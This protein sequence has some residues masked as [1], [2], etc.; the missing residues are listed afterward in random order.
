M[1]R[2]GWLVL[3][4]GSRYPVSRFF[5]WS[6][7]SCSA[8]C[9]FPFVCF[10]ALPLC[11]FVCLPSWRGG[12]HLAQWGDQICCVIGW[13]RLFLRRDISWFIN[14]GQQCYVF[15][16]LERVCSGFGETSLLVYRWGFCL[17]CP[18]VFTALCYLLFFCLFSAL[19]FH[20]RYLI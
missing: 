19:G 9:V 16:L 4:L 8:F 17:I 5:C 13:G 14:V 1:F 10:V 6:F 15:W 12:V 7:S 2:P 11:F 20:A 3:Q 18:D